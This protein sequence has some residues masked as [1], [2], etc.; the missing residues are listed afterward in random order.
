MNLHST[1]I[2]R[3]LPVL[4]LAAISVTQSF[5]QAVP[6]TLE[7]AVDSALS[8]NDKIK[9]YRHKVK[10]KAELSSSAT[11]NYLPS[12]GVV[13]GYSYFSDNTEVNMSQVKPSIDNIAGQY[14]A[15]IAKALG[16]SDQTREALQKIIT[17]SLNKLPTYNVVI[18]QQQ[19]PNLNIVAL[20]PIYTGGKI[21]AGKRYAEADR[22]LSEIEL[23]TINDEI[24]KET[25]ERYL[26]V[27]LLKR[28]VAT[29]KEVLAGMKHHE[30]DA[31]KAIKVGL[32]APHQILRAQ[33]A[34]ANAERD[35]SD[36]LN[37]L[38]LAK[39]ALKTSMALNP[40]DNI[41]LADS[42]VYF[43]VD[44]SLEALQNEA[45]TDNPVFAMIQQKKVMVDQK[46]ALE[47][48]QFLPEIGAFGTYNFFRN[49]YPL[50]P[51]RFIVGIQMKI[52]LFHGLKDYHALQAAKYLKK[53]VAQAD[54]YA[55]KQIDLLINKSYLD[56]INY[57]TRY[58][59]FEPT[60]K[61]A[62][63]NFEINEKRF[64]E[65]LA[66]ST[67]VIDARLLYEG[68]QLERLF[69]LYKYYLAV[70]NLYVSAGHPHKIV[71]ILK[72]M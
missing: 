2:R 67:D 53:E 29:R 42:M 34:V 31:K 65:G 32:I 47:R 70:L 51:P 3:C 56:V 22:E 20:Q 11:G 23:K 35:L 58:E 57:R 59:K 28:V 24:I 5:S 26:S 41:E 49:E 9:Q 10:E 55:H 61:L 27:A 25:V 15:D 1:T 39:L 43:P 40:D 64:K 36:D 48:S 37:K 72:G 50:I 63:K 54:V 38:E 62:K 18:D 45:H 14:G 4:L 66:K 68:A 8:N 69:S 46:H 71:N 60:E 44:I 30:R 21:T 7:A 13:A 6:Y 12:V 17:G 19:Y 33:V 16:L 52:N